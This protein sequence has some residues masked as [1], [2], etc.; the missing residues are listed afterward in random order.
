MYTKDMKE[1]RIT[2]SKIV[3]SA[4]HLSPKG[5]YTFHEVTGVLPGCRKECKLTFSPMHGTIWVQPLFGYNGKAN[6]KPEDWEALVLSSPVTIRIN[7]G[8]VSLTPDI[9]SDAY[10]DA[11]RIVTCE[12]ITNTKDV[13]PNYVPKF[14]PIIFR[15]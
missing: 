4:N 10:D 5:Y 14:D 11:L 8:K 9:I 6:I 3:V 7:D 1:L 12:A 2:Q 15:P 13:S